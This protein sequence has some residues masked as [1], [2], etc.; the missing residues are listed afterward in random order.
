MI[1]VTL[2]PESANSKLFN[3]AVSDMQNWV[4][5]Q[6][7]RITGKLKY[8]SGDNQITRAWGEGNF[9][10]LKFLSNN[11]DQYTSVK[12]GFRTGSGLVEIIDDPDKNG[13]WRI[14]NPTNSVFVIESTNGVDTLT[15][16]FVLDLSVEKA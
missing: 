5:I 16:E 14:K 12:V 13:V 10:C 3:V 4:L 8:L 6:D 7:N 11:W 9:L 2:K 1:A 15:Q